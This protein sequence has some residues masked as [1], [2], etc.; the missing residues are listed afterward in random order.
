ME[1]ANKIISEY[2]NSGKKV[3]VRLDILP[4]IFRDDEFELMKALGADSVN[5]NEFQYGRLGAKT[6]EKLN[7]DVPSVSVYSPKNLFYFEKQTS[8]C[9][10]ICNNLIFVFTNRIMI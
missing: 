9:I 1:I 2:E 4:M 5:F 7:G 6:V 3:D 10:T 8:Y